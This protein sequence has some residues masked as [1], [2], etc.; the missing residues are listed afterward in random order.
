MRRILLIIIILLIGV[1][2]FSSKLEKKNQNVTSFLEDNSRSQV[3]ERLIFIPYWSFTDSIVI[4]NYD[5]AIYFGLSIDEEGI[6]TDDEG[7]RKLS[8]FSN[9]IDENKKKYLTLRI[10]GE[11]ASDSYL[12]NTLWQKKI[13]EEISG[14]AKEYEFDGIVVDFE[15]SAFGF[16]SK[17]EKVTAMYKVLHEEV[18][19]QN[20]EFI[21]T[22]FGDNYYRARP[23]NIKEINNIS[24]QVIIMAYDFH[25]ARLN[26]GPNFPLSDKATYGYDMGSMISDFKKDLDFEKITVILG[27]FGYDWKLDNGVSVGMAE[28][29]SL[30]QIKSRFINNC[31]FESCK[32][33]VNGDYESVI[34]YTDNEEYLHEV[35]FEDEDSA[36]K[37][38]DFLNSIGINRIASW[39]YSYY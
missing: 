13:G 25:K 38:I 16:K 37:K 8:L 9:L 28:P 33:E 18:K 21:V 27:Y 34:Y 30:N 5:S 24:D 29:L 23:Y 12:E 26:P 7:Y 36:G 6:D 35:W 19:K 20:L 17:E 2:F 10:I 14:L 4:D 11:D 1:F 3:A 39:A 15:T 31:N 32:R 22:V